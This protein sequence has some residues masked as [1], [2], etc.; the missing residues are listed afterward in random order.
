MKKVSVIIPTYN[1]RQLLG[2]VLDSLC[3]LII[4]FN[5]MEVIIVDDGSTDGTDQMLSHR[6]DPFELRLISHTQSQGPA[7]ARNHGARE[8]RGELLAF[9]DS[10]IVVDK[11]WWQAAAS[12]FDDLN[13]AAVEGATIPFKKTIAA[14]PFTHVVANLT[15]GQFLTCNI[16]YRKDKFWEAGGF[17]ERFEKADR[18]DSDLAFSILEKGYQIKYEPQAMVRHPI[19]YAGKKIHFKKAT[20]GIHEPLLRRKHPQLIKRYLKWIDGRTFPVFYWGVFLGG[21]IAVLG[22]GV[23]SELL[24]GFGTVL[25][26]LG[27][28]GSVYAVCRK[29]KVSLKDGLLVGLQ[30]LILPWLKLFW[31]LYGEWKFRHVKPKKRR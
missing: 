12:H 2:Q 7:K 9:L 27:W 10:D 29:R 19:V 16:I 8:A 6:Q 13:V 23:K 14:T 17:D 20:Y 30:F 25:F 15:G 11:N 24:L 31:V 26:L 18:E 5:I 3:E 28:S 21:I 4:E 22:L 1:R